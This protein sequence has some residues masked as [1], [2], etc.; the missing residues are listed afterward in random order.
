MS[1]E[2]AYSSVSV[3]IKIVFLDVTR[4]IDLGPQSHD[5]SRRR[6]M[7]LRNDAPFIFFLLISEPILFKKQMYGIS[8]TKPMAKQ[9]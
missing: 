4:L 2:I 1:L 7:F 6:I 5:I 8:T 9:K 3:D